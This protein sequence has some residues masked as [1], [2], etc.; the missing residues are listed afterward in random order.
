VITLAVS[1]VNGLRASTPHNLT[2]R[3]FGLDL[4]LTSS[5][6]YVFLG[7]INHTISVYSVWLLV[8]LSI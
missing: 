5:F 4:R 6:S 8:V 7:W 2:Q 1:D 3:G